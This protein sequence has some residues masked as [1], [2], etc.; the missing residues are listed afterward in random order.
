MRWSRSRLH[1]YGFASCAGS[2]ELSSS[3]P[4]ALL[5]AAFRSLLGLIQASTTPPMG[6][7][8]I[9]TPATHVW[10]GCLVGL[11]AILQIY[12]AL[13]FSVLGPKTACG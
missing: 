5:A 4:V 6:E 3:P 11:L 13:H 9:L 7:R 2:R 8:R 1:G 12:P 10:Q